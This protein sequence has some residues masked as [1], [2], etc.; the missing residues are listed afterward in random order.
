MKVCL[1]HKLW[2]LL[3][4]VM[5]FPGVAC[6]FGQSSTNT[7]ARFNAVQGLWGDINNLYVADTGNFTIR[8]IDRQTGSVT[9]LAGSAGQMGFANGTG[10]AARFGYPSAVWADGSNIYV[11]DDPNGLRMIAP[12]AVVTTL[13]T[14]SALGTVTLGG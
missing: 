6:L 14:S 9:T 1:W 3:S 10:S 2:I 5:V 7:I 8:Q 13:A 11:A 4:L 12:G